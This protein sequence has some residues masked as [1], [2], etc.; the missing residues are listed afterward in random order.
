MIENEEYRGKNGITYVFKKIP[1]IDGE[2][3]KALRKK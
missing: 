3:V 1:Y 2:Y